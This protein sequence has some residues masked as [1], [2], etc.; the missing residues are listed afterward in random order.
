MF[1]EELGDERSGEVE[2][3]GLIIGELVSERSDGDN[4]KEGPFTDL[5]RLGGFFAEPFSDAGPV[6]EEVTFKVEHLGGVDERG[7]FRRFEMGL[8]ELLSGSESCAKR[9]R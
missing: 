1:V 5:V 3:E 4:G 9:T 2:H 8:L 6:C 7:D